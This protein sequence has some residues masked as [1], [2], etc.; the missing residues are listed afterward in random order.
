MSTQ[1]ILMLDY[2]GP[3]VS[4]LDL[5]DEV[6]EH[7][8]LSSVVLKTV[9]V[10]ALSSTCHRLQRVLLRS[11]AIWKT[12][13]STTFVEISRSVEKIVETMAQ[14]GDDDLHTLWQKLFV[15]RFLAGKLVRLEVGKMS[16]KLFHR[17]DLSNLDMV[18][19]VDLIPEFDEQTKDLEDPQHTKVRTCL[20]RSGLVC[21]VITCDHYIF[22]RNTGA[23]ENLKIFIFLHVGHGVYF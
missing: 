10:V 15:Q 20:L 21:T 6:I 18:N 11:A 5:P 7:I 16:K 12:L 13:F 1:D 17:Q 23:R 2:H 9:D 4:L 3:G 19:F 8:V 22:R 14:N